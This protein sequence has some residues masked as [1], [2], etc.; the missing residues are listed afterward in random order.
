M[1]KGTCSADD[2]D[3]PLRSRGLCN[4]HYR[5]LRIANGYRP[6]TPGKCVVDTCDL[7]AN[8]ARGWCDGHYERWRQDGDVDA[9][10]PLRRLRP[11]RTCAVATCNQPTHANGWC[12]T[13]DDRQRRTGSVQ[14][15]VP[16]KPMFRFKGAVAPVCSVAT[17]DEATDSRGLCRGH[18][19]RFMKTGDVQADVP[20]RRPRRVAGSCEKPDCDDPMFALGVCKRHWERDYY[21]AKPERAFRAAHRRRARKRKAHVED[22]DRQAVFERDGWVCQLCRKPIDPTIAWPHSMSPSLDHGIPLGKG[23]LHSMANCQAA[24]LG[25]NISKGDGRDGSGQ[26]ARRSRVAGVV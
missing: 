15:D 25:C 16:V 1:P 4:K 23:G 26:R 20:L 12:R 9:E 5:D 6:A 21:K 3:E 14:A 11:G 22:V 2:C 18:Y 24:H 13:H 17:C 7:P 19:R 8:G 10:R